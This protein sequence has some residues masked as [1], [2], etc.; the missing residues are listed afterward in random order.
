MFAVRVLSRANNKVE[1]RMDNHRHPL[2]PV[3]SLGGFASFTDGT[4]PV[5]YGVL[6]LFLLWV[7]D[8]R[9]GEPW[10]LS[11]VAVQKVSD[12]KYKFLGEHCPGLSLAILELEGAGATLARPRFTNFKLRNN[13]DGYKADVWGDQRGG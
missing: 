3:I 9:D 2:P 4:N 7:P 5:S 8:S 13:T 10:L 11:I 1:L 6:E 12:T